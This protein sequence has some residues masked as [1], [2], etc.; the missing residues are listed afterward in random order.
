MSKIE[1]IQFKQHSVS[2]RL[3]P[4]YYPECHLRLKTKFYFLPLLLLNLH[5][6]SIAKSK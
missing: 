6:N 4:L 3:D 5:W 2:N 1:K